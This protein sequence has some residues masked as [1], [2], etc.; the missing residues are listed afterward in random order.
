RNYL[1]WRRNRREPVPEIDDGKAAANTSLPS[2]EDSPD[3]ALIR[4]E[5]ILQI[6]NAIDRLPHDL[7]TVL[8]LYEYESLSYAEIA[9]V[10]G[11][12]VKAAE[13]KLYR[14]RQSLRE[15]LSRSGLA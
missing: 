4:S 13:M 11:C 5:T 12:S 10:L 3:Q 9:A 14:A 7:K 8:L 1:R 6:R 15:R 2:A